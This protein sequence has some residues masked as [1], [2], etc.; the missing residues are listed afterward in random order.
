MNNRNALQKNKVIQ[1]KKQSFRVVIDGRYLAG[2]RLLKS[3][4]D[5]GLTSVKDHAYEFETAQ[6]AVSTIDLLKLS[7]RVEP[8]K[9]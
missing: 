2:F 6:S 7:G 4:F 1:F 8:V 3:G 9:V 5:Y